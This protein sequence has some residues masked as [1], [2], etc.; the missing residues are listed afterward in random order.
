MLPMI[1]VRE[2]LGTLLAADATTLAPAMNANEI[3]LIV[4]P[5]ALSENTVVGSLTLASFAG[6]TP[7]PCTVGAQGVG[8]DPATNE[9]LI[10]ILAPAGG[11]RFVSTG[12]VS[13]PQ[14]VYGYALLTHAGATLLALQELDAPVTI[15][16]AG[17]EI[18]LG[19]VVMTFVLNPL[20]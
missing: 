13:P 19:A 8:I 15:T 12:A 17:Q 18:D 1:A 10:T 14:T 16:L 20:N 3:A 11:W 7:I 9:Q 2:Q 5:F 6:S 4:A